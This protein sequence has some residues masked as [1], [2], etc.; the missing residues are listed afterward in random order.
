MRITSRQFAV[1]AVIAVVAGISAA[2]SAHSITPSTRYASPGGVSAGAC[3]KA[4]PCAIVRAIN[5]APSG[6]TV[7]IE[8]GTY[9]SASSPIT[10]EL[11]DSV[12]RA[13][14]SIHG[15]SRTSFPVIYSSAI[16]GLEL[17][18]GS[19]VSA[20]KMVSSGTSAGVMT[21]PPGASGHLI[22]VASAATFG[23]CK[24]DGG[25]LSDSLCIS[26]GANDNA[27]ELDAFDDES[28]TISGVTAIATGSEGTALVD[29]SAGSNTTSITATNSIFQGV[30]DD[31]LATSATGGNSS[32]TVS[33]SEYANSGTSDM[34]NGVSN[35]FG[36]NTDIESTPRFVDEATGNYRERRG[37][38]TID[39]GSR[40]P[41]GD[42]DLA[43]NPRTLGSEPDMG[44]YEFLVKPTAARLKVRSTTSHSA[45]LTVA[46]NPEGLT[47]K[48]KLLA[49]SGKHHLAS[50]TRSAGHARKGR[51]VQLEVRGL[52]PG[53]RYRIHAIATNKGG[54][55][56]SN[57]TTAKAKK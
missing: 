15:E 26:T 42:T 41:A 46:V 25:S 10:T 5:Q 20:L 24:I 53:V 27:V 36:D 45:D 52:R 6:S 7:I 28:A 8:P 3:G 30:Q 23:A 43:G 21:G 9:G 4:K 2:P 14:L 55:V 11:T 35:I 32:I 37:S 18:S 38:A 54:Q 50:A 49:V 51:L 44:A 1:L 13:D 56:R 19:T 17:L 40:V 33:H 47:T 39:Q 31:L 16:V 57:A 48:V 22:V 29:Q 12:A 34:G